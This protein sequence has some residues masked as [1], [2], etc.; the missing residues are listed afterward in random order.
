MAWQNAA[1]AKQNQKYALTLANS[2]LKS[3]HRQWAQAGQI[4]AAQAAS[5]LDVGG[6]SAKAVQTS[7]HLVPQMDLNTIREKAA[8]TAMTSRFRRRTTRNQA[9]AIPKLPAM[10]ETEGSWC[11]LFVY[12]LCRICFQQ[13]DAGQQLGMWGKG[14]FNRP[15][16]APIR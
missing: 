1:I 13:M 7:Q 4:K 11:G 14:D 15:I 6:G 8:K 2:R 5:G 12:R 10:P 16:P 9:K 3:W